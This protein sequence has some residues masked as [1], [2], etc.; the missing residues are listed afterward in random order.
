MSCNLRTLTVEE[1]APGESVWISDNV[2]SAVMPYIPA[3]QLW[4]FAAVWKAMNVPPVAKPTNTQRMVPPEADGAR[5]RA[6]GEMREKA[7]GDAVE[8]PTPSVMVDTD[9]RVEILAERLAAVE[10]DVLSRFADHETR[11][12]ALEKEARII[13]HL[14]NDFSQLERNLHHLGGVVKTLEKTDLEDGR[15]IKALEADMG[16]IRGDMP[17]IFPPKAEPVVYHFEYGGFPP[18]TVK[19]TGTT[20]KSSPQIA[21][22]IAELVIGDGLLVSQENSSGPSTEAYEKMV[23]AAMQYRAAKE[24]EGK[25]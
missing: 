17:G 18:N 23:S 3:D 11:V 1:V 7:A 10:D 8:G 21:V 12:L 6:A 14:P 9:G 24:R 15:R 16:R 2:L 13:G 20:P 5:D 19:F 25:R 4:K 22:E